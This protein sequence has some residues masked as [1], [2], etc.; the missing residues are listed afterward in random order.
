MKPE[1]II[2][3]HSLTKDSKTVSWQ[4]IRHYHMVNLGWRAIGYHY[5]IELVNGHY[6]IIKG[7]M[8]DETGAHCKQHQMNRKSLGI[9]MVGNY[10]EDIPDIVQ[11]HKLTMLT[12]SLMHIHG[13]PVERVHPHSLH[14]P[15]TCPGKLF[16]WD[17]FIS[18]LENGEE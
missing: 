9:C 7:R 15:K 6:E 3:H 12:R 16:P 8:D 18:G 17:D 2:I 10:D 1:Y 14:A 4:A 11:I 13:I 5:G